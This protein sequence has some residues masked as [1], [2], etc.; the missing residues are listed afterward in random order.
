M[1]NI[2]LLI[3]GFILAGAPVACDDF[4]DMNKNPNRPDN[5]V[6]YNFL[7]AQLGSIFRTSV[8]AIE[9]DD[10]QRVKSLMV[11][12]YGQ[13]LDGGGFS[14]RYY[15]MID[16]WSNRMYRRVQIGISNMNIV[17]RGL[18]ESNPDAVANAKAVAKIWRVWIASVGVDWFGP[19]PFA[20]YEGEVLGNP[21]YRS[22]EDIYEE[23]FEELAEAN[24]ILSSGNANPIFRNS[25]YDII[26]Q[27][28]K[29]KWRRFGNSLHLR[30]AM[31]LTEI[32]GATA[33]SEATEAIAAG[34]MQSPNDNA[35]LPP[36]NSG[37]G[38]DYNY[39][40]FQ[41]T[42]GGP[43]NLTVSMEKL[44]T[45]IGG[46]NFP[47]VGIENKR[48]GTDLSATHP[49][50]VD[51]RGPVMFDPAFQTGDWK[52]FPDGLN[53][54]L[55]GELTAANY[56][57]VDFSEIGFMYKDGGPYK[58]RPYDLF[59]Y[60]EVLFLQ[61]EA[62]LRN[63]TAA[64]EKAL[65]EAGVNAS[66]ATWGVSAQASTYL[67]STEVNTAG[68]SASFDDNTGDFSVAGVGGG[69][70]KLEKIITQK[71]LALFP[72][73][74]QEAWNDKRRLNLPRTEVAMDRYTAIWPTPS[75]NVKDPANYIKRVQ[76]PNNEILTN[77][78]EYDKG[79]ILLGGDD[80][81]NTKIWWDLGKNYCTSAN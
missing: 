32:D 25:K 59:L 11:D 30:L 6:N 76:Y 12:F 24:T 27:N 43:L 78:E 40:M 52:G 64:D 20:S 35:K 33:A 31:R 75:T 37:W 23:F 17:L 55:H 8:P 51:P 49:A 54:N 72:D 44:L 45:G 5:S 70:T 69:N 77:E 9:G 47:T 29:E 57:S 66:F 39:T 22:P 38:Q 26:F 14:T 50:K 13:Q 79:V 10:E 60:E 80:L 3:M 48:S 2:R 1:K 81:V 53:I 15:Q 16:D 56:E 42:W 19:I 41:I 73:M 36:S 71:Y 46:I 63:Y 67:A 18:E 34:V 58:K 74:S 68:T 65:Y 21:P 28:D 4:G 61:A 7:E 62:A